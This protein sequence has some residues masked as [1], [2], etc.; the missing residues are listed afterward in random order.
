MSYSVK[1][2]LFLMEYLIHEWWL[3]LNNNPSTKYF[4]RFTKMLL[5]YSKWSKNPFQSSRKNLNKKLINKIVRQQSKI[6]S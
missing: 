2:K 3:N 6:L 5:Q 4:S 1:S